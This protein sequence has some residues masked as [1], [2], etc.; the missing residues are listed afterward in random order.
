MRRERG[1][2]RG[3]EEDVVV[4]ACVPDPLAKETGDDPCSGMGSTVNA[5]HHVHLVCV[6]W[7][8]WACSLGPTKL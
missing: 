8:E 6:V 4:L 1:R 7:P 5:L 2:P 3:L